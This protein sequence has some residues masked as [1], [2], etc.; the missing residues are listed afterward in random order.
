[1]MNKL[2]LIQRVDRLSCNWVSTGDPKWPLVCIWKGSKTSQ[3]AIT[4]SSTEETG[5]MHLCA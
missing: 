5:R 3:A 4:A 2:Y 1:M